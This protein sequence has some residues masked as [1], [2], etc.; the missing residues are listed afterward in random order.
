MGLM[1]VEMMARLK[2]DDIDGARNYGVQD[3]IGCS[4]CSYVCPSKIPLV[5]YFNYAKGALDT[6]ETA[7]A[8]ALQTKEMA[9]ARQDRLTRQAAE[10]QAKREA[11]KAAKAKKQQAEDSANS[12]AGTVRQ[13]PEKNIIATDFGLDQN[14]LAQ[15]PQQKEVS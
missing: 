7:A 14:S 2:V 6:Q 11:Q 8:K 13:K 3:C 9:L 1:P 12:E 5:Q 4:C 15:T 10:R